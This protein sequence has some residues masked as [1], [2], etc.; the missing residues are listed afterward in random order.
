MYTLK[1]VTKTHFS[2][3]FILKYFFPLSRTFAYYLYILGK[4]RIYLKLYQKVNS[5]RHLRTLNAKS[6]ITTAFKRFICSFLQ[7][8]CHIDV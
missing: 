8:F 4:R 6:Y 1:H 5:F 3:E 2:I 7:F